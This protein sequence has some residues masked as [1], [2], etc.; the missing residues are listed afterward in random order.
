MATEGRIVAQLSRAWDEWN[1][2]NIAPLWH[3]SPTEDPTAPARPAP[4]KAK[5]K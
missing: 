4:A 2:H 5:G 1:T 3:G